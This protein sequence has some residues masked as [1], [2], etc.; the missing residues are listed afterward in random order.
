MLGRETLWYFKGAWMIVTPAMILV[1]IVC[2]IDV[3]SQVDLGKKYFWFLAQLL[4]YV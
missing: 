2:F 4:N 1:R 3:S